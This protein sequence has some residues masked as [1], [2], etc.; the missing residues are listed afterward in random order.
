M[1]EKRSLQVCRLNDNLNKL[2]ALETKL[3]MGFS[4][5]NRGRGRGRGRGGG[6]GGRGGGDRGGGG[7]D[8]G[9]GGGDRGR[10]GGGRGRGKNAS[11]S[12][13]LFFHIQKHY[14]KKC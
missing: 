4:D 6:G 14:T 13:P 11:L 7:G 1:D 2:S 9:R 3:Y 5:F 10:G 12:Y 8:R